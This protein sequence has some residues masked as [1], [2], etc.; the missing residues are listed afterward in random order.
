MLGDPGSPSRWQ[1]NGLLAAP[2]G[3]RSGEIMRC[4]SVTLTSGG[5][6]VVSMSEIPSSTAGYRRFRRFRKDQERAVE[7]VKIQNTHSTESTRLILINSPHR[8]EE[9]AVM[10]VK[11]PQS[12][13]SLSWMGTSRLCPQE[14]E[15]ELAALRARPMLLKGKK[16]SPK[17]GLGVYQRPTGM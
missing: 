3:W 11:M 16:T 4:Q 8:T 6:V 7:D 9:N 10:A 14:A 2:G 15:R 1:Y 17:V 13:P 12:S 5:V